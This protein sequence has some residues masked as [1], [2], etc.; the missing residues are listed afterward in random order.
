MVEA[1]ILEEVVG[2]AADQEEMVV[3]VEGAMRGTV[4]QF[5]TYS[6]LRSV[7]K[8]Q[9]AFDNDAPGS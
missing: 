5:P 1:A 8:R 3:V 2:E 7:E 9:I 4:V 6:T